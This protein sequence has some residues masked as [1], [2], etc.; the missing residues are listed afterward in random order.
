MAE[1]VIQ[2]I[3]LKLWKN[4]AGLTE[5]DRFDS[6]LFRMAQ[7]QCFSHF[8]RVAKETVILAQLQ[9]EAGV[10]E[11]DAENT[12]AAREIQQKIREVLAQLP[13]QQKLVY[14]L[15]REEGLKHDEIAERL[16]IS[17]STVKNHMIKALS[18]VREQMAAHART[19][20]YV[21]CLLAIIEAFEK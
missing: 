11:T 2:D 5:I 19:G 20:A 1:D 7:N 16:N 8:K 12:L 21:S 6:Y 15:S 3:F 14:T 17:P 18:F 4:R 13:P 10:S 9:K